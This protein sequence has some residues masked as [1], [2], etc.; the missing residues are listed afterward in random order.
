MASAITVVVKVRHFATEYITYI[1]NIQN[2]K[3]YI[4][5]FNKLN[6][7]LKRLIYEYDPTYKDIYNIVLEEFKKKCILKH[8]HKFNNYSVKE[9][10]KQIKRE[11]QEEDNINIKI[12]Y[13]VLNNLQTQLKQTNAHP[14]LINFTI[15]INKPNKKDFVYY[16]VPQIRP[17]PTAY[18]ISIFKII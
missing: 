11:K 13:N 17:T 16:V 14:T 4:I 3:E 2:N 15:A 18:G 12:K 5:I 9:W 6:D 8:K 1:Q 10:R 7:N